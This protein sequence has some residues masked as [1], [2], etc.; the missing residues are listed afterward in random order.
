[1][2][3]STAPLASAAS[4]SRAMPTP[5]TISATRP[6]LRPGFGVSEAVIAACPFASGRGEDQRARPREGEAGGRCRLRLRPAAERPD[7]QLEE[8]R[9]AGL[10]ERAGV[11]VHH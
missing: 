6:E 2:P 10:R 3:T 7:E 4:A 11:E 5:T 8:P 9:P 1:M